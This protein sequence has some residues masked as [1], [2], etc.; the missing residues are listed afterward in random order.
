[1]LRCARALLVSV[2]VFT[3][4][5]AAD[6]STLLLRPQP[7]VDPAVIAARYGFTITSQ[8]GRQHLFVVE[9]P[10]SITQAN[11]DAIVASDPDIV[12]LEFSP[13]IGLS[14]LTDPALTQSVAAILESYDYVTTY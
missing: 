2:M 13:R 7:T 4:A 5:A 3:S 10:D 12:V 14:S 6:A 11:L 8:L 1:M 9:A